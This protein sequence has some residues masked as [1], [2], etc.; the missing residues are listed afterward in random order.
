MIASLVFV[1]PFSLCFA[2]QAI[3]M[4]EDIAMFE[5]IAQLYSKIILLIHHLG[6]IDFATKSALIITTHN[7]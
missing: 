7:F 5:E 4:F 6:F 1:W 2:K 3:A